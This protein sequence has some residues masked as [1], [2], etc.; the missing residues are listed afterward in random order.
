MGRAL[1]FRDKGCRFPGCTNT[2][3]VDG[4]HIKHWADGG[5][6]S[7][8]NLVQLCRQHHRLVHEGGFG[9]ERRPDGTFVFKDVRS[10]PI[11][12][13]V[14]LPEIDPRID[15]YDWFGR[16]LALPRC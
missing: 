10:L 12:S 2:R 8:D 9:C 15:L 6:T 7:L 4:Y 11:S 16:D 1:R 3:Y 14:L 5:E 13:S